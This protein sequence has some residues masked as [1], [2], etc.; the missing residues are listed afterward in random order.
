MDLVPKVG[1]WIKN[2]LL[3]LSLGVVLSSFAVGVHAAEADHS[4]EPGRELPQPS[5]SGH[6]IPGLLFRVFVER[7]AE[8]AAVGAL[9]EAEANAALQ[10]V[11]NTLSYLNQQRQHYPRF[12]EAVTKGMLERVIVQPVVRNQEGKAFPFLVVRTVDPGRVR[13]LISASLMKKNG[14]LGQADRFTP[15]LAREFQ[16]VVSK[17]ET[18]PKPKAV[19]IDRDLKHA[20]IRSDKDIRSLSGEDRVQLL[21]QLFETY[22]R[23]VDDFRS[24]EGQSYYEVGSINLVSPSQPDSTTKFYD[25]RVRE[26]LQKILREPVFLERTP[27]AMTSLLNG[28]I[29]NVTFVNIDQRDWA[30]RTRVLPAEKAVMVGQP[31]KLIQPAA[32]LINLHRTAVPDDPFYADTKQL[33]MGALST[34]QLALVIAKEIQHNIVEKSQTGHVA[35]D[36]LTAPE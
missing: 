32:I 11:R 15:V 2:G 1:F 14:Y 4:G 27:R 31:G 26:A 16:W 17:A 19:L 34:D 35:Q 33:P 23:T 20:P 30:T 22:L 36:A 6:P 21:Q 5:E 18:T 12:D 13:L 29:W 9:G 8:G 25:I 28:V 10:T 3:T 24:L 7:G